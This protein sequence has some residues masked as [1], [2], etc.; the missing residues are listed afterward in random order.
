MSTLKTC[1]IGWAAAL[2]FLLFCPGTYGFPGDCNG[3]GT[4]DLSDA[5]FLMSYLTSGGSLPN[6][7]DCD[8]DNFP[9][10]NIGDFFQLTAGIIDPTFFPTPGTDLVAPSSTGIMISGK[11][12]GTTATKTFIFINNPSAIGGGFT[13]PF[14][15]AAKPGEADLDCISVTVNPM[16]PG[17]YASINNVRK[18]FQL[19]R[20]GAVVATSNW[21][22]LCEV[23]FAPQAG[24][25]SGSA[26]TVR[27]TTVARF[28]P[29]MVKTSAYFGPDYV[30]MQFPNF[31]P[32]TFGLVGD[33]NCD[34]MVDIADGVYLIAYIFK[35]GPK[36]GDPDADG[37]PECPGL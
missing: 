18:T 14:S 9:G 17:V 35:G 6:Y 21:E 12:D 25:N 5:V 4:I 1:L 22:V 23:N 20:L 32:D 36:P 37:T 24:G 19:N 3:D 26:V 2:L 29:V 34:G 16:F 28:F 10:V 7:D 33:A 27:P 30:R 31:I 8:C 13:L 15:F 11:V